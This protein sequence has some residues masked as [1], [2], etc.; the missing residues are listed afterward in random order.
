MPPQLS[1]SRCRCLS[2]QASTFHRCQGIHNRTILALMETRSMTW[3]VFG[4]SCTPGKCWC[5]LFH[6]CM[7]SFTELLQVNASAKLHMNS[8]MPISKLLNLFTC[9]L[10]LHVGILHRRPWCAAM[11]TSSGISSS[12]HQVYEC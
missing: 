9:A 4:G 6:M 10:I 3:K 2:A 8:V 7:A 1:K 5:G 12:I 11:N